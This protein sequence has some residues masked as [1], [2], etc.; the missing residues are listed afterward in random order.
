MTDRYAVIGN[1]VAHSKSPLI[2]AAFARATG[3]DIAYDRILAPLDGFDAAV[4][5][6]AAAGGRGLN[7]TMPFKL[8][9]YALASTLSERARVA[10]AVN[11]LRLDPGGWHGDNTDGVG[12]TRDLVQNLGVSIAGRDV[13]ILGAGGA[14]RG[15]L[16]PL[17]WQ[18]PRTLTVANRTVDKAVTLAADFVAYGEVRAASAAA[19]EGRSFD[20]VIHATGASVTGEAAPAWPVTI[21]APGSF[22][23]DLSYADEPTAFIRWARA[24]GAAGTADGLGMLV[25]QAAESFFVWRRVRPDTRPVLA[26]LRASL[27]AG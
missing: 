13:L 14:A 27:R 10:G 8:E 26:S 18:K 24:H 23:Y 5:Q 6:F 1:P 20:V 12:V 15:I 25:E 9:A 17:L 3:D 22:A 4:A 16:A 11:T 19:L 7:V 2:H 21:F